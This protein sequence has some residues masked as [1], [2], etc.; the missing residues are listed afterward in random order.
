MHKDLQPKIWDVFLYSGESQILDSRLKLLNDYCDYFVIVESAYTF[1]G[2]SRNT[3][4]LKFRNA[5]KRK[6]PG[7]IKWIITQNLDETLNAWQREAWQRN[8]IKTGLEGIEMSDVIFL[9][10]VDEIPNQKFVDR[11]RKIIEGEFLVAKMNQ[12]YYDYDFDSIE[13]W[14]GT[15]ATKWQ[16]NL[17]F[18]ELRIKAI[19]HWNLSNSEVVVDAGN[20]YSSIGDSK[21]LSEKIRSFSHTEFNVFPFNN[22]SFLSILIFLGIKFDGSEVLE[23]SPKLDKNV[24]FLC[25]RSHRFDG[26]RKMVAIGVQPFVAN[27]YRIQVGDLSSPIEG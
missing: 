9:S 4:D 8:Q 12:H 23:Y 27:L 1:S 15:I 22:S 3:T 2:R 7:K 25:T 24:D 19:S 17:D 10:D 5:F 20:H 14:F 16:K 26:L 21:N 6:Y 11:A 13:D 18:Q